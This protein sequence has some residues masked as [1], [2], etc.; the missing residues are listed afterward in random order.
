MSIVHFLSRLV[1]ASLL[2]LSIQSA[3]LDS[4]TGLADDEIASLVA[5]QQELPINF[6]IRVAA[7]FRNPLVEGAFYRRASCWYPFSWQQLVPTATKPSFAPDLYEQLVQQEWGRN[8]GAYFDERVRVARSG[9]IAL[10]EEE[11]IFKRIEKIEQIS[12]V[13]SPRNMLT[14][15]CNEYQELCVRIMRNK[16]AFPFQAMSH[17]LRAH[18]LKK[19]VAQYPD[20]AQHIYVPEVYA[21][22]RRGLLTYN[23]RPSRLLIDKNYVIVEKRVTDVPTA[24]ENE[25]R[26]AR[27]PLNTALAGIKTIKKVGLWSVNLLN[28]HIL[29]LM[30]KEK[31]GKTKKVKLLFTHFIL[32][33]DGTYRADE[34]FDRSPVVTERLAHKGLC[35]FARLLPLRIL[36]DYRVRDALGEKLWH[37]VVIERDCKIVDK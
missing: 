5:R 11:T 1:F 25:K 24:V 18:Q 16:A 36:A 2:F 13:A 32:P 21:V 6:R 10:T 33:N 15:C 31:R 4:L 12:F 29:F 37:D 28:T 17:V 23:Q 19:V 14:F 7:L 9:V 22:H 30:E 35:E 8:N 3:P 26:F 20:L 27:I 34:Y